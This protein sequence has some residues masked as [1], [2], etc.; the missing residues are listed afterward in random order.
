MKPCDAMPTHHSSLLPFPQ[1]KGQMTSSMSRQVRLSDVVLH[2]CVNQ[3]TYKASREITFEP[4]DG[5]SFELLRCSIEPYVSPPINVSALM[6]YDEQRNTVRI[7]ASFTVRK[8]LNLRQRP[9]RDMVMKFPISSS[10]SPLFRAERT[11]GGKTAVRSTAALR[12]SFR[13]KVSTTR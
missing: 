7:T 4:V 1:G 2:P 10:W 13:R 3:D 8:K 9:V 12:G 6:E 5:F 11:F